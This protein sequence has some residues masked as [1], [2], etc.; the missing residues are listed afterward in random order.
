MEDDLLSRVTDEVADLWDEAFRCAAA[1]GGGL[2][3]IEHLVVALTS[4]PASALVL[5][6]RGVDVA[7]LQSRALWL[8]AANAG[9]VD[10]A[11]HRVEAD[12]DLDTALA[13]AVEIAHERHGGLAGCED[14]M[15]ALDCYEAADA[16]LAQLVA[17]TRAAGVVPHHNA[18]SQMNDRIDQHLTASVR[19][20][21]NVRH[22]DHS[23]P[24]A[25][26]A[27]VLAARTS[28]HADVQRP[29]GLA[30]RLADMGREFSDRIARLSQQVED[31]RQRIAHTLRELSRQRERLPQAEDWRSQMQEI[32]VRLDAVAQR[33]SD[34]ELALGKRKRGGD[35]SGHSTDGDAHGEKIASVEAALERQQREIERIAAA[36]VL[37]APAQQARS[38]DE[39]G[40]VLRSTF[41]RASRSR[42]FVAGAPAPLRGIRRALGR[43]VRRQW[44]CFGGLRYTSVTRIG[45]KRRP[46]RRERSWWRY[47]TDAARWRAA[48]RQGGRFSRFGERHSSKRRRHSRRIALSPRPTQELREPQGTPA[49]ALAAAA[50]PAET[51][52]KRFY[53]SLDDDIVDAPSIGPRTAERL[54]PARIFT[55][56]DLLAADPDEVGMLVTARHITAQAVRDWQDQARLV[57]TVPFLRGTHAQLLV[58]AGFRSAK[59]VAE[60]D[61]ASLMS[62]LLTFA[63]SRDGQGILRNGPPPDIEKVLG[64]MR[65]AADADVARAA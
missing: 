4:V 39:N 33:Q 15:A 62:A 2:V 37:R 29:D 56:R 65:N 50:K 51:P 31:D 36:L 45:L 22:G 7:A 14:L 10:Y 42:A 18:H 54:R 20:M 23:G 17:M 59:M 21:H 3:G 38:A 5:A 63:T 40:T 9:E 60:A 55:V 43:G 44:R 16:G 1:Y 58:G 48:R 52:E 53:L 47:M 24:D 61:Q 35:A 34:A 49:V 19:A 25:R 12:D 32:V 41:R 46:M 57:I 6:Q 27:G 11:H 8:V 64:W 13:L 28:S 30:M 26:A